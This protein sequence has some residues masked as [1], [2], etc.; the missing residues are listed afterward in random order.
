VLHR[1]LQVSDGLSWTRW[2]A[3]QTAMCAIPRRNDTQSTHST[4]K[5]LRPNAAGRSSEIERIHFACP[6]GKI[7]SW[8]APYVS[9]TYSLPAL[10]STRAVPGRLF[11]GHDWTSRVS[12]PRV[13]AN[14]SFLACATTHK[15]TTRDR[16][17][18][19]AHTSTGTHIDACAF[20]Q[21]AHK[22]STPSH[23]ATPSST[24]TRHPTVAERPSPPR[25][26]FEHT[27]YSVLQVLACPIQTAPPDSLKRCSK[28]G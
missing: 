2:R 14:D 8:K 11:S 3:S 12:L 25:H 27:L 16:A 18:K 9:N 5:I 20:T 23:A 7:A 24:D 1:V 21:L 26:I 6:L 4:M 15:Y 10:V 22:T 19:Q 13:D 17:R 28:T